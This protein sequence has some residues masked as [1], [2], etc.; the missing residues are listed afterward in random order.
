MSLRSTPPWWNASLD[1]DRATDATRG[2]IDR[3]R[4]RSTAGQMN[5]HLAAPSERHAPSVP[6]AWRAALTRR[7]DPE[8]TGSWGAASIEL[9][10]DAKTGD[11]GSELLVLSGLVGDGIPSVRDRLLG[12][13][14]VE[15]L[16]E[17][18]RNRS[19]E[20]ILL[21]R[22]GQRDPQV[23]DHVLVLERRLD[24][25][26]VVVRCSLAEVGLE[27]RL[28]VRELGRP[29]GVEAGPA[30]GHVDGRDGR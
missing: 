12:A 29:I 1:R 26:V 16:G 30:E 2:K 23:E 9:S 25:R 22:L 20:H 3:T 8:G 19:V 4:M 10:L 11:V 15:L 13:G 5:S 14:G 6:V 21:V 27:P 18:L 7:A 17:V 28:L 24:R